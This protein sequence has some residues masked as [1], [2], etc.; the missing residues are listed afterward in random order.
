MEGV[1]VI[2]FYK[3][4]CPTCQLTLPFVEKL[5]KA[6]GDSV[7]FL[8]IV[9]DPEGE[10]RKFMEDYG[11][12]FTQLIDAPDYRVSSD[13]MVDVVP[14]IYLVDGGNRVLFVEESF[15]KAGLEKLTSELARLSGKEEID[16][17]GGVS[18]P[19]FKAG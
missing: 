8:G 17:F 18:V 1:K 11:L 9:Q 7:T 14:T 10:A 12:T 4:T 2:T 19:P 13:Y 15:L 6:Y 16:L 3:V 5:H